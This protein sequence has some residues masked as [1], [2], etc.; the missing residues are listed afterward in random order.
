MGALSAA[1]LAAD[2]P[3]FATAV[4]SLAVGA[5]TTNPVHDQGGYDISM[6]YARTASTWSVRHILVSAATP[7]TVTSRPDWFTEALFSTVEALC[8]QG[9]IQVYISDA[10]ANPCVAPSP[11]PSA[12]AKATTAP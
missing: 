1:T 7:Y 10:G 6:L 2:D 9:Q 4:R 8:Q 11:S 3:A 12:T 5:Y